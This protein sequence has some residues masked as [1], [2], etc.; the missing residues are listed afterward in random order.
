M[1][2]T[3]VRMLRSLDAISVE[4]SVYPGTPDVNY[5][6]RDVNGRRVEGWL[7]LK[8]AADWPARGGPLRLPH[9]TA[10]Q[11]AW[12]RRRH[13]RGGRI[14]LLLQVNRLEWFLLDGRTA[15]EYLGNLTRDGIILAAQRYS[16]SGLDGEELIRWLSEDSHMGSDF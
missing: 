14:H 7:E 1:R 4:N 12:L 13:H 2:Q 6:G 5:G 8:W 16:L 11:R 3:V 10:E 9:F 15:G